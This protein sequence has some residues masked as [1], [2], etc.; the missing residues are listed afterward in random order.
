MSFISTLYDYIYSSV[1]TAFPTK[2]ELKNPEDITDNTEPSL[3]DGFGIHVESLVSTNEIE[4]RLKVFEREFKIV[5]TRK[6]IKSELNNAARRATEKLLLEDQNTF[7]QAILSNTNIISR[8]IDYQIIDDEGMQ[9]IFKDQ[10]NFL[11]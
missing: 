8:V 10:K 1:T 6:A 3:V 9:F 4:Q 2:T 7:V 5:F 11:K